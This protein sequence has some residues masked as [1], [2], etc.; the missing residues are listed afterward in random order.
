MQPRL[1]GSA[2]ALIGSLQYGSGIFSSLLI[3]A[4]PGGSGTM[5]AVMAVFALG[6]AAAAPRGR[7][8][9]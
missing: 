5:T 2:T 8:K 6:A 4:L 7:V 1:A 9:D 3:A